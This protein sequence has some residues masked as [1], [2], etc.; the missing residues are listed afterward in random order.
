MDGSSVHRLA[1]VLSTDLVGYAAYM[2]SDEELTERVVSGVLD[3]KSKAVAGYGG[4]VVHTAGDG[5]I[6]VFDSALSALGCGVEMAKA[7]EEA[8]IHGAR[9]RF[10]TGLTIGE[11]ISRGAEVFGDTVNLAKRLEQE[12]EPGW[13]CVSR[14]LYEQVRNKC[15]YGFEF[16]GPRS[17]KHFPDPVEVYRVLED[18][19]LGVLA[20]ARRDPP[21]PF[22]SAIPSIAVM[23]LADMSEERTKGWLCDAISERVIDGLARFKDLLVISRNSSFLLRGADLSTGDI[24]RQLGVRYLLLGSVRFA[25]ENARVTVRLVSAGSHATLWSETYHGSLG[26]V[27]NLEDEISAAIAGVL[28][29]RIAET[30]I[31]QARRGSVSGSAY[32]LFVR[33][34]A[35]FRSLDDVGFGESEDLC[36]KAIAADSGFASAWSFLSQVVSMRW[37]YSSSPKRDELLDEA[38]ACARKALALD[39]VDAQAHAALG[40]VLL[41][42]K[43]VARAIAEYERAIALNPNDADILADFGD[44]LQYAGRGEEAVRLIEKAMRLNPFY[45]DTYLWYLADTYFVL[46]RYEEAIDAVGSMHNPSQGRRIL[47]ACYALLGRMD[48]ARAQAAEVMRLYPD[49]SVSRWSDVQ[50]DT[51][52]GVLG[53]FGEALRMAGL[54]N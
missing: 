41:Y 13:V 35:C 34:K 47:A 6:A 53:T 22:P 29:G 40:F 20:P 7:Q 23:P 10:R 27:F 54:P 33:A 52:P 43:K 5:L 9:L 39:D 18:A 24:G 49:F 15:S 19:S 48:E 16:L 28:H 4:R 21:E 38:E 25:K 46:G 30:E 17:L 1:A 11:V 14:A 37:R 32:S 2:N 36:R 50:P 3:R 42:Q 44:A 45:P 31:Q 51:V 26:D 12:A 8:A